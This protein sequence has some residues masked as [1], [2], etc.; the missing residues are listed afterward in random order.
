MTVTL[1]PQT[2]AWQECVP[3]LNTHHPLPWGKR[4]LSGDEL[5]IVLGKG[6]CPVERLSSLPVSMPL[7]FLGISGGGCWGPPLQKT[8]G[9]GWAVLGATSPRYRI[10]RGGLGSGPCFG[11][12]LAL[13]SLCRGASL[14]LCLSVCPLISFYKV[15]R[16]VELE[17]MRMT[18][19]RR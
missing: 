19:F 5:Q 15:T 13:L 1:R 16:L 7:P 9:V 3:G 18:S 4:L 14:S 11:L 10:S 8:W 6:V 12:K 2:A 17:P